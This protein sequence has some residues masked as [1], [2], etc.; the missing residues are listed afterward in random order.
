M[1]VSFENVSWVMVMVIHEINKKSLKMRIQLNLCVDVKMLL[2][3][4]YY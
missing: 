2:Y 4:T 1:C 3:V